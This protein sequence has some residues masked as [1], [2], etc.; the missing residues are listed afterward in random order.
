MLKTWTFSILE[1]VCCCLL[2]HLL[3][4]G[5][6]SFAL[7]HSP[8]ARMIW[9]LKTFLILR[10][11]KNSSY[12]F[13]QWICPCAVRLKQVSLFYLPS[14]HQISTLEKTKFF[15]SVPFWVAWWVSV[16]NKSHR[17]L[18]CSVWGLRGDWLSDL[19]FPKL[20]DAT[21]GST[22]GIL[23][24]HRETKFIIGFDVAVTFFTWFFLRS[25]RHH[26]QDN[27]WNWNGWCWT[28]HKRW[29]HS[30]RVKFP[31]VSMSASWFF[32]LDRMTGWYCLTWTQT[33]ESQHELQDTC[34]RKHEHQIR[35]R[36][37]SAHTC[38]S[39]KELKATAD[40]RLA[41]TVGTYFKS[42]PLPISTR[43]D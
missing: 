41:P 18:C 35:I 25:F 9:I 14:I 17:F 10:R 11:C 5:S 28:K 13:Q 32:G 1:N 22:S 38:H 36:H 39:S 29:F 15:I 42:A 8:C 7:D 16:L 2:L 3:R 30:S 12:H 23:S 31:L 19:V 40:S 43:Q 6:A 34:R 24:L 27:W 37:S 4:I 21:E 33:Q 26:F 20:S